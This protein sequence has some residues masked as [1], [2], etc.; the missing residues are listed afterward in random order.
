MPEF[1]KGQT[2]Y[3]HDGAT[4]VFDHVHEKDAYVYPVIIVQSTTYHG[5]DFEEHETEA[6]HL[7]RVPLDRLTVKPPVDKLAAEID[8]QKKVLADLKTEH[9]A[10]VS[11]QRDTIMQLDNELR[12]AEKALANW[13]EKNP[14]IEELCIMLEGG[15]LYP[16]HAETSPYYKAP[17]IPRV[18]K[19][20]TI[21]YLTLTRN[22]RDGEVRW[23]GSVGK[24]R[25][26]SREMHLIFFKSE[27]ERNAFILTQ[28]EQFC[29]VFRKKPDY[30]MD[31]K[32]YSTRCDYGRAVL[33]A[34]RFDFCHIP[35]DIEAGKAE[36]DAEV[37]RQRAEVLRK[38]LEEVENA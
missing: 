16:L 28:F 3:T 4:V 15:E 6:D 31:G 37:R 13:R 33:W 17:E 29:E 36:Y 35:D 30:G 32:T 5:D 20:E 2:C 9:R 10:Q 24:Y 18:P 14:F 25:S 19:D 26:D 11:S 23:I 34:E 8:A 12:A 7:I 1:R 22:K 21:H 38:Q 27:E